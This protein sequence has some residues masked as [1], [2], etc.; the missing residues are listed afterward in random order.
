MFLYQIK[1]FF[2]ISSALSVDIQQKYILNI[3][4]VSKY[5]SWN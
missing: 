2:F 3:Y 1:I 5:L 4:N